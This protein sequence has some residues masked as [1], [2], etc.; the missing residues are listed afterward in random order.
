MDPLLVLVGP[1]A[2][3]KSRAAIPLARALDAEIVSLDSMLLYR[4]M[5]IGTDK[6]RDTGGVPHHLIDLLDPR[7]RFDVRRYI[8]LA[9]EAIAGIRG[10]GRRVLV[11]GGTGLYLMALLK[12]VFEGPRCDALLR[13]SLAAV[14]SA[15]LHRRLAAVDP[16]TAGALHPND[17]RRITRALEVYE[18]TGKPLREQQT[19]FRGPDRHPA[20][21]AGIRRPRERLRARIR[22]RIDEMFA[23][24][25]VDE[26]RRL[27][28]GPTASQ[29]VG[30]KEVLGFLRGEYDLAEARRLVERN[31]IRLARRQ[32]TWFKR[33][34]VRWIDGE[35]P[36]PVGR[37]A[38][39][40]R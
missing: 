14:P 24:G 3:G 18:A 30:Y 28:L 16:A 19:Q 15:E 40:L 38:L 32:E 9:E 26:V 22:E 27:D 5:D 12:G 1:T 37:L 8:D 33:F 31:T 2:S 35:A 11:V 17:R 25:L 7:E 23:K 21:I 29:A 6:P 20:V 13:A 34:P 10:R 4:G 39:A 36:D